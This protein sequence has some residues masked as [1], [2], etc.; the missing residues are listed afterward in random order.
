MVFAT[1]VLNDGVSWCF[2]SFFK[3]FIFWAVKGLKKLPKMKN[4]HYIR[5]APYLRNSKAYYDFW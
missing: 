5:D 1:L 4:N 3:N 2:F